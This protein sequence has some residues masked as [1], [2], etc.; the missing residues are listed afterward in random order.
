L[1]G[2]LD[3]WK[4]QVLFPTVA[5]RPTPE[6]A[7]RFARLKAISAHFGGTPQAGAAGQRAVPRALPK[8]AAPPA[9]AGAKPP[10][11]KRKE[12]C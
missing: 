6:E 1:F 10:A 5:E 7:A 11:K 9:P 8:V 12:G 3:E 4:D 2:G